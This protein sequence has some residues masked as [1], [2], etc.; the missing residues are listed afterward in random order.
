M[1]TYKNYQIVRVYNYSDGTS[2]FEVFKGDSERGVMMH[3]KT[4]EEVKQFID[5]L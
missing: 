3:K 4:L 2:D 1:E 5:S